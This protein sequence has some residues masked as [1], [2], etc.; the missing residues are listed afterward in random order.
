M[1]T[2]P[3]RRVDFSPSAVPEGFVV[4]FCCFFF[5]F[6]FGRRR[7]PLSTLWRRIVKS[8]R[9]VDV[10]WISPGRPLLNRNP[11]AVVVFSLSVLELAT[12]SVPVS[13]WSAGVSLAAP[14]GMLNGTLVY[15]ASFGG[16]D[17]L[18]IGRPSP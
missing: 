9:C 5:V 6:G 16:F 13:G 14:N 18:F 1:L 12:V 11:V 15:E 4:G 3:G 17:S 7:P 8:V 10:I 2:F